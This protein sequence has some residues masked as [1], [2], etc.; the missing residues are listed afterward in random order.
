M[1]GE[2]IFASGDNNHF[3]KV[4]MSPLGAYFSSTASDAMMQV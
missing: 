2:N 4:S 1:A 3:Q